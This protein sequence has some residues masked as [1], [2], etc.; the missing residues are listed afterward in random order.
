MP[1]WKNEIRKRLAPLKL[2][3]AREEEIAEELA[4]HLEDRYQDL[5]V[6]GK[7]ET[8]ARDLALGE[9]SKQDLLARRL[10]HVEQEV[11]QEPI[12]PG[13]RGGKNLFSSIWQD[14]RHG[15]RMLGRNPGFTAVVVLSLALGIGANTAI[16][17]LIDAVMLKMLPVE[18]PE[19]L[20]LLTW[21]SQS[22]RGTVPWFLHSLSGNSDQDDSGRFTSTAFSYAIFEDIRLQNRVFSSVLAIADADRLNVSVGGQ[23]GIAHGQ[24]VSGDYFSTL[25]VH[26]AIGRTITPTDDTEGASPTAMISYS[27]WNRRFGRDPL[28]VG[29]AIA[30]NGVPFTLVGVTAPEFYGVEP[31]TSIDIWIPLHTQPKIDPGWTAYATPGEVSKF[32]ARDDW[33]VLIMGRLKPGVSDPQARAALNRVVQWSV[34]GIQ[35]PPQHSLDLAS[36]PPQVELSA[37]S[38][39]LDS[40]RREFSEPLSILMAV[41]GLVLLIACANVANLSLAR[42]TSRRKE[43]ALRLALGAGRQRLIRQLLTESVMLAFMG[44][45]LGVIL[46]YWAGGVLLS[47]MSGGRN[48]VILQLSP[49]LRVLG[50]TATVSVLTGILFGLAPALSGTRVDLT[51]ALKEGGTRIGGAGGRTLGL[52]K[53]LGK[54][55]VVVQVA[56]S[57]LLLIGAGLFVRTL[58]NLESENIGFDRS[59]LLLFSIDPTQDGYKGARL[60][61][62][63]DELRRRIDAIPGV[64]SASLS[65]HT[66][67]NGGVTIDGISIQGYTP[68]AGESNTNASVSLHVNSVGPEFFETFGIPLVLGRTIGDR[69][70]PGAPKV[71]VANSAFARKYLENASPIGRRFGFGDQKSSS[72]IVIVG[73]VGDARY[74]QLRNEAPPTIYIPYAQNVQELA[75]MNF[76]VRTVGDPSQWIGA[77]RQTVQELDRNLPL[78]DVKTQ[79]EQI[80]QATFQ[81]RLFARLSSFFGLLALTLACVGL[82]GIMSYSVARRTNEIGIRMALGAQRRQIL[83]LILS[84]A[85]RLLAIGMALGLLAAW[86]ASRLVSGMLYGLAPTDPSTIAAA[87]VVL[88][89]V[90]LAASFLPARRA[91]KVDPMVALR[92]E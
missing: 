48:P 89:T 7:S 53:E 83:R 10:R 79:T 49:D 13:G 72:D 60:T 59:N 42:A 41:V 80:E 36:E 28:A 86:W 44:G 24:L 68:K 19:H 47:F 90:A 2:S 39:G 84:S 75:D 92:Y 35:P 25:G 58:T 76:E 40:L 73:V 11:A 52:S 46:A 69:D 65:R 88:A 17:S 9:L 70:T 74:G 63:Y 27:Y 82:Y 15:L 91:T 43:I 5:L 33:W 23:A 64:R 51:P 32:T 81:E 16:F 62:F 29:K 22:P 45:A 31:G 38:K 37:A 34:A 3:P 71:A 8:K 4:Q 87:V 6:R 77:I 66:F 85:L 54:A 56:L 61:T 55:L 21:A 12:V 26:A 30:V 20:V 57:L 78:F 67:I 1:E 18:Q 14:I 50:F